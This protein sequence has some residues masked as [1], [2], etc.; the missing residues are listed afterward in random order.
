MKS[1]RQR[2]LV[3]GI[4]IALVVASLAAFLASPSPDGLERVA[5][6]HG[7]IQQ[8]KEAPYNVLPDYTVPGLGEGPLST[9]AAGAVGVLVVTGITVGAG[10]LLRRRNGR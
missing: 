5:G 6:D 10:V 1:I 3:V 8:A 7:F 9:V 4:V 2:L